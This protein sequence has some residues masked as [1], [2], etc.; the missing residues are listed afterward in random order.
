MGVGNCY[1]SLFFIGSVVL[2]PLSKLQTPPT[3]NLPAE[4]GRLIV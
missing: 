3:S 1:Y 2:Q 4:K